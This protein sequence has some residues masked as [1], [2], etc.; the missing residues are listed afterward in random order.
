MSRSQVLGLILLVLSILA[1]VYCIEHP[2]QETSEEEHGRRLEDSPFR[3][4]MYWE[5]GYFW[6]ESRREKRYCAQCKR[7]CNHGDQVWIRTCDGRSSRQYFVSVG[8]TL[9]PNRNRGVCLTRTAERQIRLYKC[10]PGLPQQEWYGITFDD[11][12]ELV[13]NSVKKCF[14]QHHHPR[15]TEVLY[16]DKCDLSRLYKTSY[17]VTI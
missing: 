8:K 13:G 16:M 11:K 6:Q 7:S 17:W 9:R 12:F 10:V 5:K 4:K 14:T 1:D 2:G 15:S 3:L